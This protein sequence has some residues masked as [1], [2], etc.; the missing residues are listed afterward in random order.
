[1]KLTQAKSLTKEEEIVSEV[2]IEVDEQIQK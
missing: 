1:L 2:E